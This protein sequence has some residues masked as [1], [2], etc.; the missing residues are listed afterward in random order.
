MAEN[1]KQSI[2]ELVGHTPLLRLSNFEKKHGLQA[3]IVVK[4]EYYNP[5][6][7]VKDR[8]A[9]AMIENAE[10][11]GLLKAGDT[12][13]EATSGNTGIGVGAIAVAKGYKFRIYIQDNVSEERFKVIR[14][15]GGEVIKLTEEPELKEVF[16]KTGGDF[17]AVLTKL[18]ETL[19]KQENVFYVNQ[20][21]NPNNPKAHETTTGPEIWQDTNGRVDYL[22]ACVGTGGTISGTGKYL[23]SKNPDLKV[24]AIQPTKSSI[25]TAENPNVEEIT[26]VH[27]FEGVP[28][29]FIP[30]TFDRT[31]YDEYAEV[32]TQQA[33]EIVREV[34][35]TDGILIGTSSGASIYTALQ[36]A[37]RP[38]NKGKRIVA[39]VPDTGLRYL[40]TPLFE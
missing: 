34:A 24:V 2:T 22:V 17:I 13:V 33:F 14:A 28:E 7:S 5:N 37:K 18:K 3:E 30:Q 38:E 11:S 8:I 29:K 4:L 31:I 20:I 27:P 23:K 39:I 21:E 15:F 12:I 36:I 19:E 32:E 9:L 1:I 40:S 16:E 25:A 26:G 10:K 35:K 6:Q